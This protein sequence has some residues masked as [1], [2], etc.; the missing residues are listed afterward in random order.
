MKASGVVAQDLTSMA[1]S[2]WR[3]RLSAVTAATLLFEALTGLAI[4]LLPFGRGTQFSLILHTLGGIAL[5]GPVLWYVVRHWWV[6]QRG[7]LSHYQFV[8]YIAAALLLVCIVSGFVV[9]W[10]GFVGPRMSRSWEVVHLTTGIGLTLFTVA[11]VVMVAL[12]KANNPETREALRRARY[13]YYRRLLMGCGALLVLCVVWTAIYREPGQDRAFPRDYNWRFGDDRPFA[14]SMA[15]VEHSDWTQMV[16]RGVFAAVGSEHGEAFRTA[17]QRPTVEPVGLLTRVRQCAATARLDPAKQERLARVVVTAADSVKQG[18]AIEA[19]A[20]AGSSG[21]G[22]AGCH[23]QIYNEWSPS[24]HR[25]A[26]MDALFQRVQEF[27]AKETSPEHTRYCAGCHDPISLFSGAKNSGNITLSALGADEG[28]S[29]LVCHSIVQTDVQGNGDYTIRPPERYVYEQH[30]GRFAKLLSDFLIRTYPGHHVTSYSRSLYKTP[31]FCGACHK[32]YVDREVNTDIGK[33]QGQNQYDSWKNSRWFHDGDPM[34]TVGCRECHFPL[35]DSTDPARGDATDY[36]RSAGDLKHRSHRTL[37][38]N[39]YVPALHNLPGHQ[40]HIALTE[41]WLRGE[42]AIPEIANKWTEGPVVRLEITAPPAVAPGE[43]FTLLVTLTNNKTGHDFPTGPLDMIESWLEIR[44]T[45]GQG[46]DVY[47]TGTTGPGGDVENT[48]VWFKSDGFDRRRDPIDRHNLWD[49]VGARNKRALFAG[50]T[51]SVE[52]PLEC[53]SL[54]RGRLSSGDSHRPGRREEKHV[55]PAPSGVE[56]D[57]QVSAVLLYRK[58]NPMFLNRI[59]GVEA[60]VRSPITQI[61]SAHLTIKVRPDESTA[62]Q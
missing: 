46:R 56:G 54:Q 37:A 58:A 41:K 53:P 4:Y 18:G 39:Q 7:N 62:A 51:D 25:Y 43:K 35:V 47:H 38:S 6:R 27:M 10:Q 61:S 57:L 2:E 5:L 20:L 50:A 13:A 42:I 28:I 8:G 48:R 14:P 9:T 16:E 40:Q 1:V 34:R 45:N 12:R 60:E 24:A 49:L 26:S 3:S 23:E 21:C 30:D 19:R 44:V 15:R 31:E 29:C 55:V 52:V 17:M 22:T 59:Y 32:Q 36:N 11:H 33:V